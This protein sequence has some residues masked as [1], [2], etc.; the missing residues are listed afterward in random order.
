MQ[1]MASEGAYLQVQVRSF[2]VPGCIIGL[3]SRLRVATLPQPGIH[4]STFLFFFPLRRTRTALPGRAATVRPRPAPRSS[5]EFPRRLLIAYPPPAPPASAAHAPSRRFSRERA[6]VLPTSETSS[7][8]RFL[9]EL[10]VFSSPCLSKLL[11]KNATRP[12]V[13]SWPP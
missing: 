1:F 6:Q 3:S 11:E 5:R 10:R 9:L 8:C 7:G 4:T 13:T 12:V 2:P